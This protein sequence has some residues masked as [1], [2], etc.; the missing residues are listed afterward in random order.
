MVV[1]NVNTI[2]YMYIRIPG[3]LEVSEGMVTVYGAHV[4]VC[5]S[6]G[7]CILCV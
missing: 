6:T 2:L 3:L 1:Q 7:Y 4:A 5:G